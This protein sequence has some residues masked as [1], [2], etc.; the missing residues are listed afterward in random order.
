[1]RSVHTLTIGLLLV[2]AA[3]A[4]AATVA[5]D[6]TLSIEI[7]GRTVLEAYDAGTV[8]VSGGT[9]YLPAGLISLESKV[10]VAVT[11]IS[12]IDALRLEKGVSNL[13]ATFR[14]GGVTTQ[15]P[16]ELCPATGNPPVGGA[17][18]AGG[19]IGGHLALS[20]S[21]LVFLDGLHPI[22]PVNLNAALIG[23]GGS[24]N[25]PITF[26]AA[27][28][29]TGTGLITGASG[30]YRTS[31]GGVGPLSLVTPVFVNVDSLVYHVPSFF[32]RLTLTN[33]PEPSAAALIAIG[34]L[35]LALVV[36]RAK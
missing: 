24:T 4:R 19:G 36:P 1:M 23:Q 12:G 18:N 30:T 6:V 34:I 32:M 13:A 14:A 11:G 15:V 17:C 9:V 10:S 22:I 5:T 28:W 35:G 27:A 25:V 20:G 33:V 7:G 16:S 3:P 31:V 29:S 26:D 2:V 21:L 8:T